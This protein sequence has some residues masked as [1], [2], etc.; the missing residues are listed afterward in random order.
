MTN[1]RLFQLIV[2]LF[3]AVFS[4][5]SCTEEQQTEKSRQAADSLLNA[6]YELRDYQSLLVLVDEL[7][8]L[9]SI[10]QMKSSYWRGYAY[11]RLRQLRLAEVAWKEAVSLPVQTDEDLSY[12]AKS[13]NRLAGLLYIKMDLPF[14]IMNNSL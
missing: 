12:Y 4:F 5:M 9:G 14:Q 3:V 1:K 2:A 7:D 10:T 8:S 6:A 11:S 13:A